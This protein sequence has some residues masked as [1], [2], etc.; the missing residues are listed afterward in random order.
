MAQDF[1]RSAIERVG[2][3][4]DTYDQG[5]RTYMLGIYNYMSLG[6][7]L[8]GLVA[9]LLSTSPTLMQAIFGTGL[10]YIVMLAPLGFV[11][12]LSFR[13]HTMSVPTAQMVF[14][15]FAVSMG[16]SLSSIFLLYT[17]ASIAKTFFIASGTFAGMSLYGYTT[18]RDLSQFGSFLFMGLIGLVLASLVNLFMQSSAL[19]FALSVIGVFVFV[20]LTAYD[21][22][23]IKGMY[24]SGEDAVTRE[25]KSIMGALRLYLDLLNL[26]LYLLRF[27]GERRN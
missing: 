26:T 2:A 9:F 24:Y 10:R 16:L 5:L 19:E 13:I 23:M 3:R 21:T 17:G 4:A 12:F 20:G 22:Q 11:L 25:K 6:L 15:A 14:W 27:L 8:T 18:Q 7:A 1:D